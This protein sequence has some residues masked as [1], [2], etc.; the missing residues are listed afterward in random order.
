MDDSQSPL[1]I[2][3]ARH[4]IL[5]ALLLARAP[6]TYVMLR[7]AVKHY[8]IPEKYFRQHVSYLVGKGYVEIVNT[9]QAP[10]WRQQVYRL[11]PSGD[12]VANRLVVDPAL[13]P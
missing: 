6:L 9:K 12:E 2:K 3:Q 10:E 8:E 1:V 4:G 7:T 11:T 5:D 13:E